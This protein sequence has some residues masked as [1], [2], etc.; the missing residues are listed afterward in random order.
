VTLAQIKL[1]LV[2]PFDLLLTNEST[3][4]SCF[5]CS[6]VVKCKCLRV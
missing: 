4:S 6:N 5:V 1:G 2:E 3:Q